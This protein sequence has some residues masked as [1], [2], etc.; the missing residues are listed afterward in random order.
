MEGVDVPASRLGSRVERAAY[1]ATNE[2][3][4]GFM[5]SNRFV[6]RVEYEEI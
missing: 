6:I 1:W 2:K 5:R 4:F 3:K